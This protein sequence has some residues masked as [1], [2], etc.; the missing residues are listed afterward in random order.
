MKTETEIKPVRWQITWIVLIA[1]A[2]SGL[3]AAF[4]FDYTVAAW[5]R[6]NTSPQV[7]HAMIIVSRIG[8]W[9]AHV[10]VCTIGI[11]ISFAR[12]K[13]N[14]MRI[15]VA[16]LIA[17]ILAGLTGRVIKIATGRA[18]PSVN[19]EQHWNG[20]QLSSKYHAFP[21]G[22]TAISTAFFVALFLVRKRLGAPLLL[23]PIV[24]ASSRMVVGAHYLSDVTFAAILGVACAIVA[25]HWV[26]PICASGDALVS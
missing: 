16:M 3:A 23:I 24:I 19:T 22:H 18:R 13:R 11:V 5:L 4:F 25:V 9:P 6:A 8:D 15:F 21:S 26:C 1:V 17:L 14:W 12:K 10:I 2:V 20:W 7:K